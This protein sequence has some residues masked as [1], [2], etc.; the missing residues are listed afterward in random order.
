MCVC[1]C[2][3]VCVYHLIPILQDSD[4]NAGQL[5]ENI[6]KNR[7]KDIL[8]YEVG[9]VYTFVTFVSC[10]LSCLLLVRNVHNVRELV[11]L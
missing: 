9:L 3:C 7:Y 8:P 6:P 11:Y 5:P 1:V 4:I 2:V 10:L